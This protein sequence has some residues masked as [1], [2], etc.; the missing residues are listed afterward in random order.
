MEK[1]SKVYSVHT[2]AMIMCSN[3]KEC[4]NFTSIMGNVTEEDW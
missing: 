3:F 4:F 1:G 2:N